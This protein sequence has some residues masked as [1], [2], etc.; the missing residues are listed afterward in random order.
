MCKK[1]GWPNLVLA[2][3]AAKDT[4]MEQGCDFRRLSPAAAIA[5]A[6]SLANHNRL[7]TTFDH[8]TTRGPLRRLCDLTTLPPAVVTQLL[9]IYPA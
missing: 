2:G 9:S 6:S 5:Q 8:L 7:S 1:S 3:A 4:A